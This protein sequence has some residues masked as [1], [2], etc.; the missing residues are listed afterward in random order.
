MSESL[1]LPDQLTGLNLSEDKNNDLNLKQTE[2]NTRS[3]QIISR[4]KRSNSSGETQLIGRKNK[5]PE[6]GQYAWNR[7]LFKEDLG[8]GSYGLVKLVHDRQDNNFY[9]MKI[10]SKKKLV[11]QAGFARRPPRRGGNIKRTTPLDRVYQ[12]IALL[13]KL[14]HPNVVKLV[15]VFDDPTEDD[16]CMV[17][18]LMPNGE[19]MTIP[20]EPFD[21]KTAKKYSIDVLKGLQYLHH[22]HIIHRDIKPSNLLLDNHG[23]VKIADLGVSHQ[24]DG[25]DDFIT[26]TAGTPAFMSPES[27]STQNSKFQGKPLDV[28]SFGCTIYCFVIGRPP[29]QSQSI[30]ELHQQIKNDQPDFKSSNLSAEVHDLIYSM[31]EKNPLNRITLDQVAR[32]AWLGLTGDDVSNDVCDVINVTESD[33]Q[34]C[35]TSVPKLHTLIMVKSMLKHR[36]FRTNLK[37]V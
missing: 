26:G 12:E 15:E 20:C 4:E 27:I 3:L 13:K 19:V 22:Q 28:W 16:L 18:E 8:N 10:L 31:L 37:K 11:R 23:N 35:V 17:F 6:D 34:S 14:D 2:L 32:H 36:T 25:D 7:Y 21:E 1:D 33:V 24:Y 9:A 5:N 29:F 30:I